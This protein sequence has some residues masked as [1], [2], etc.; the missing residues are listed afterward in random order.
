[1]NFRLRIFN[2]ATSFRDKTL[3]RAEVHQKPEHTDPVTLGSF[4]K[5]HLL[6]CHSNWLLKLPVVA[7]RTASFHR[8]PSIRTSSSTASQKIPHIL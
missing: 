7:C 2:D 3:L 4:C 6:K 1:M 5:V 8:R